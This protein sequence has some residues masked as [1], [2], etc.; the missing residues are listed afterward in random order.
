MT[1]GDAYG[2]STNRR[3]ND[4]AARALIPHGRPLTSGWVP[5]MLPNSSVE[6]EQLLRF[7]RAS[8]S[9]GDPHQV[10]VRSFDLR[11]LSCSCRAGQFGRLC[12]AVVDVTA[13]NLLP[14][15]RQRWLQA[16]GQTDIR[17]AAR[18]LSQVRRWANAAAE[19]ASLRSCDC[20]VTTARRQ[21]EIVA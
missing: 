19:L 18:V 5:K 17:A 13:V 12:W 6:A 16:C 8:H 10:I 1:T 7:M 11:P 14:L 15:A 20:V 21:Q 4:V 9:D 3:L 2:L